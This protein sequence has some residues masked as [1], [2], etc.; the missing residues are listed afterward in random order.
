MPRKKC[1]TCKTILKA[2]EEGNDPEEFDWSNVLPTIAILAVVPATII[3][4]YVYSFFTQ[5]P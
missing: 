3:T 5:Q 4:A 2:L 1:G